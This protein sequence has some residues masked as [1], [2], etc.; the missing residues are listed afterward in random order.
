MVGGNGAFFPLTKPPLPIST[1]VFSHGVMLAVTTTGCH[2]HQ[3][4]ST[5]KFPPHQPPPSRKH[6]SATATNSPP[7]N[8]H[9]NPTISN[10]LVPA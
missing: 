8:I 9:Q 3:A 10:G 6:N 5:K 7:R 2:Q 1:P 4:K